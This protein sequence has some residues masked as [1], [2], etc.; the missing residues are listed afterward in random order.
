MR[1][2]SGAQLI[3]IATIVAGI[4]GYAVTWLVF[5]F[6]GASGYAVFAVFW[7]ALYLV[8]GGLSGIQ[9]EVTRAT[10]P[11]ELGVR[12]V[13]SRARNFAIVVAAGVLVLVIA[14]AVFWVPA[15]LPD[16]GWDLV[17]PI[18]IGAASYVLV[19]VLSGSLYGVAQWRSIA[20]LVAA[21]GLLRVTLVGVGLVFTRD[22]V[23]LAWL[24]A[25][26]FPLALALL[27]PIIRRSFVGTSDIDVGYSALSWNVAR[28]VL[29]SVSTAVLVSGFPLVLGV[30]APPAPSALL[31]QLIFAITLARAPLIV[32]VMALQSFLIVRFRDGV[33]RPVRA[34]FH[35]LGLLLVITLLAAALTVPVGPPVFALVAGPDFPL[36]GF[37][38]AVLVLSSGLVASLCVTGAATLARGRHRAYSLGWLAA[39]LATIACVVLGTDLVPTVTAALLVGPAVGL[40]VHL[41]AYVTPSNH[42]KT[43]HAG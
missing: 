12:V 32:T 16:Q 33:D 37:F 19:A 2:F 14:S 29:A 15:V 22:V 8:I 40:V 7:A 11:I 28:T 1:R 36:D 34:L 26:P 9:Q 41:I 10:R 21:D 31:G 3:I 27:W 30:A 38:I 25:L 23:L 39:A 43:P 18:A 5:R 42:R 6:V 4:A 24:V 35:I 13:A 17:W 20:L